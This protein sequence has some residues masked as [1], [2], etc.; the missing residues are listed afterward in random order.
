MVQP[1]LAER[2]RPERLEDLVGQQELVG[3]QGLLRRFWEEGTL[4]SL[5]LWGPPGSGKTSLARMLA[6]HSK[7]RFRFLSAVDAGVKDVRAVIEEGNGLFKPLL[8]LDEIHRFNKAQQDSLLGA[9]ESGQLT[10]IGAT[11]E[12]PSFGLNPALLS[13]CQLLILQPLGT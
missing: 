10:L 11:T 2:M 6:V 13:R 4:P 12:N 3:P 8:F 5:L 7:R 9:V 1:P